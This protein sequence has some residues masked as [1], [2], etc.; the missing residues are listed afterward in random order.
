[1]PYFSAL[2]TSL[3]QTKDFSLM[4]TTHSSTALKANVMTEDIYYN[5]KPQRGHC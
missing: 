5:F 2:H 3:A 4:I 1:M